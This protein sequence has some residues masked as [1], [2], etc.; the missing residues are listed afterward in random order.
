[1]VEAAPR[2]LGW[3]TSYECLS[4][5]SMVLSKWTNFFQKLS[6]F[7]VHNPF[8]GS[9]FGENSHKKIDENP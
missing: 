1:M 2:N 6:L 7:V 9:P 4:I 8:F 5:A 3:S